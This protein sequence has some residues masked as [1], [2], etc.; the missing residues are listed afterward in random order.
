[1]NDLAWLLTTAADAK[2]RDAK[3]GAELAAAAYTFSRGREP[4]YLDTQAAALAAAGQFEQALAKQREAIAVA[5][6]IG[7][8]KLVAELEKRIKPY[9]EGRIYVPPARTTGPATRP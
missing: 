9:S 3:E 6:T 4:L 5:S 1:M 2:V 7:Q 8:P